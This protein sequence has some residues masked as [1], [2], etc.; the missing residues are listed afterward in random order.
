MSETTAWS[1]TTEYAGRLES[2]PAN[3]SAMVAESVKIGGRTGFETGKNDQFKAQNRGDLWCTY[4]KKPRHTK[5]K[6]WKLH[7]KPPSHEWGQKG[8][9]P[10]GKGQAHVAVDVTQEEAK[11]EPAS[12]NQEEVERVRSF[13]SNLENLEVFVL[14]HIQVSIHFHLDLMSQKYP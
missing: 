5:E 7:G 2:L 12:L 4:C 3:G 10:Q 13:F 8:A 9:P 11:Q 6:C 1:E 14:C